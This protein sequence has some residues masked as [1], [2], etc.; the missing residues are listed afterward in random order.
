M[1]ID[2][3]RRLK[4]PNILLQD[5]G[6]NVPCKVRLAIQENCISLFKHIDTLSDIEYHDILTIDNKGRFILKSQVMQS[7]GIND[8]TEFVISAIQNQLIIRWK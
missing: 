7:T 5:I 2:K 1:K 6:M 3:Q 8:S 4:I